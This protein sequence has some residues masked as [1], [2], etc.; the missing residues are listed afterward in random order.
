[1]SL[2]HD[3]S[4]S[5]SKPARIGNSSSSS[6]YITPKISKPVH[7]NVAVQPRTTY[8]FL[9]LFMDC[10][11]CILDGHTLQV[12]C[13]NFQAQGKMKVNLLHGRCCE[14]LLQRIPIVNSGWRRV[15]FPML[16]VRDSFEK[17]G[18]MGASAMSIASIP[19]QPL[20]L[21]CDFQLLAFLLC[22]R[23]ACKDCT[24]ANRMH[25]DRQCYIPQWH[26]SLLSGGPLIRLEMTRGLRRRSRPCSDPKVLR[27]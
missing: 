25:P 17:D 2:V 3:S 7:L 8:L 22:F 24:R 19:I 26:W 27:P 4:L 13:S 23:S 5:H 15:Q 18:G 21:L 10:V 9:E 11:Q 16:Q 20:C 6:F 14:E 1:M 12:S